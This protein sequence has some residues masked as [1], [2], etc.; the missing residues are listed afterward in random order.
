MKLSEKKVKEAILNEAIRI[1]KLKSI[2]Q[3]AKI[4]NEEV[5]KINELHAFQSG[6]GP[7]FMNSGNKN[8]VGS[9]G[10]PAQSLGLVAGYGMS[11]DKNSNKDLNKVGN[12]FDLYKLDNEMSSDND[13]EIDEKQKISKLEDENNLLKNKLKE[14]GLELAQINETIKKK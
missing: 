13:E 6:L 8:G 12:L 5:R 10:M 3:Q 14:I 11:N 9:N 2:Y 7:G 4:L 1:K